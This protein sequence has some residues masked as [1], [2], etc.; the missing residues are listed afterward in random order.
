MFKEIKKYLCLTMVLICLIIFCS[1]QNESTKQEING[2]VES[3]Y[4]IK[5]YSEVPEGSITISF[6]EGK[7][8]EDSPEVIFT[9]FIR[10]STTAVIGEY[11]EDKSLELSYKK[12]K[13]LGVVYGYAPDEYIYVPI[14]EINRADEDV[15]SIPSG[16]FVEGEKYL[17]IAHYNDYFFDPHPEY[18]LSQDLFIPLDD[19]DNNFAGIL[20]VELSGE[21]DSSDLVSYVKHIAETKGYDTYNTLYIPNVFRGES[22]KQVIKNCDY[23]FEIKVEEVLSDE[24]YASSHSYSCLIKNVL[25]SKDELPYYKNEIITVNALPN[26]MEQGESYIAVLYNH[27]DM[28]NNFLTQAADNGII[29]TRDF[30]K[31]LEIYSY[32]WLP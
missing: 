15:H 4:L 32:L 5:P 20:K 16:E 9:R 14:H 13:N 2:R 1:C 12:F 28:N 3:T 10:H 21:A 17:I 22:L 6:R 31:L 24:K 27:G 30:L 8:S 18:Q 26:S 7:D 19:I 23:L 25:K 29:N 11:V